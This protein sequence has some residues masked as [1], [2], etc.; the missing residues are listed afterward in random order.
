MRWKVAWNVK[1]VASAIASHSDF[2]LERM[3]QLFCFESQFKAVLRWFKP[4]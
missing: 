3:Q 2:R 4:E 1:C